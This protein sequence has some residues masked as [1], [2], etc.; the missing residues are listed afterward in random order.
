MN[1]EEEI[2]PEAWYL[3]HEF[4]KGNTGFKVRTYTGKVG[5]TYHDKGL[6]EKRMP[7]Y[8]EGMKLPMLCDPNTL[9]LIEVIKG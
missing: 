7:V 6:V 9:T 4:R 2:Y 5:R 3:N 1:I 8:I